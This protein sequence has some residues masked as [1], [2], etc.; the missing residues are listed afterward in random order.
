MEKPARLDQKV[1]DV[2]VNFQTM[3]EGGIVR[4]SN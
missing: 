4:W 1:V 2:N 3:K